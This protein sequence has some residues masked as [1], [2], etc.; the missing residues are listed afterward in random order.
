[1]IISMHKLKEKHEITLK[2]MRV[3]FMQINCQ[4]ST[5]MPHVQKEN[6]HGFHIDI[7]F[8]YFYYFHLLFITY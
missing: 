8:Y 1:M 3:F 6:V 2:N 5:K 7:R 4:N